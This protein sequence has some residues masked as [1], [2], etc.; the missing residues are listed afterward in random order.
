MPYKFVY[1]PGL[2]KQHVFVVR[3]LWDAISAGCQKA[4]PLAPVS[5]IV[6]I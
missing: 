3:A 6:I 4:N 2:D 1:R 5:R